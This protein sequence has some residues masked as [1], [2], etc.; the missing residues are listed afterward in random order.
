MRNI[1]AGVLA[2]AAIGYLLPRQHTTEP[3]AIIKTAEAPSG[4]DS[5]CFN[6][7]MQE[8]LDYGSEHDT[9]AAATNAQLSDEK[10]REMFQ[11]T[12]Y[13]RCKAGKE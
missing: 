8:W 9:K 10:Y 7:A 4:L 2:L 6:R 1:V 12:A 5:R 13:A 3:P 11:I